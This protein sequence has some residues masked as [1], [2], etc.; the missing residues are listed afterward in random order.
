VALFDV[1]RR[2]LA[3]RKARKRAHENPSPST[4]AELA[5]TYFDQGHPQ[6]AFRTLE[7]AGNLFPDSQLL[8]DL[9]AHL[10]RSEF[11][12]QVRLLRELVEDNPEDGN[13]HLALAEIYLGVGDTN[14]VLEVVAEGLEHCRDSG[15]LLL[16]GARARLARFARDFSDRD[17]VRAVED[18]RQVVERDAENYPARR[19]AGAIRRIQP[20]GRAG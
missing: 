8:H 17:C 11:E 20:L 12:R 16:V 19:T 7:H 2:Q 10:R 18:L 9:A 15:E 6:E 3:V 4:M 1:V 5:Q 14:K 13:A